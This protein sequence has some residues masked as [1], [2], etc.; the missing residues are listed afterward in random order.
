M[1][2]KIIDKIFSISKQYQIRTN[3]IISR[4]KQSIF[5]A[6][7]STYPIRMINEWQQTQ[8]SNKP[9]NYENNNV[10][11]TINNSKN[12]KGY[13]GINRNYNNSQNNLNNINGE[14]K[15]IYNKKN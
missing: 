12:K 7:K 14:V 6:T 2:I 10:P 1:V 9:N 4:I 11:Q 13:N 5:Y 3:S 8:S 15:V